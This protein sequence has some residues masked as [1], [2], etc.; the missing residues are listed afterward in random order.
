M[1]ALA[2]PVAGAGPAAAAL[3]AEA[4]RQELLAGAAGRELQGGAALQQLLAKAAMQ[5]LLAA[6]E[7][8]TLLSVLPNVLYALLANGCDSS[9][10][11]IL[12]SALAHYTG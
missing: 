5:E 8:L 6:T 9:A 7:L 3:L 12:K 4:A 2:S 1:P 10:R 11:L